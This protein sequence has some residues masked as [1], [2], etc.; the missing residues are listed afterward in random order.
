M[1]LSH[2]IKSVAAMMPMPKKKPCVIHVKVVVN[3]DIV[4]INNLRAVRS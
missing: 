1:G 4:F 2:V 3:I